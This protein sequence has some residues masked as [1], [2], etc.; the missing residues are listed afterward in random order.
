MIAEIFVLFDAPSTT[1]DAWRPI[2]SFNA[3][4]EPYEEHD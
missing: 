2:W 3:P 4:D 1:T